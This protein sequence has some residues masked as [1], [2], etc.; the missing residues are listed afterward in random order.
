MG[1]EQNIDA[2]VQLARKTGQLKLRSKKE[3]EYYI[4]NVALP[5]IAHYN[6]NIDALAESLFR[7]TD[8]LRDSRVLF[9]EAHPDDSVL[10]AGGLIHLLHEAGCEVRNVTMTLHPSHDWQRFSATIKEGKILGHVPYAGVARA[11]KLEKSYFDLLKSDVEKE[12]QKIKL[13]QPRILPENMENELVRTVTAHHYAQRL[14]SVDSHLTDGFG[15]IMQKAIFWHLQDFKPDLVISPS[16]HDGNADHRAVNRAADDAGRRPISWWYFAGPEATPDYKTQQIVP[17]RVSDFAAKMYALQM[18]QEA[19]AK[20]AGMPN[21][22][23][24]YFN[25]QEQLTNA[26]KAGR[27][28]MPDTRF[29]APLAEA[30]AVR[31]SIGLPLTAR[32]DFAIHAR[33]GI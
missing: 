26:L 30:F 16:Y 21:G 7:G 13:R 11:D 28:A 33:K 3:W 5:E 24:S 15:Y 31:N 20:I 1:L 22:R 9:I 17:I 25:V 27:R 19:Y 8:I 23:R 32:S 2:A 14:I 6:P 10:A 18:H 12:T 29:D 4:R